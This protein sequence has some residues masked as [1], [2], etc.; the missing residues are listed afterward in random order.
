MRTRCATLSRHNCCVAT[1]GLLA[2]TTSC[3]DTVHGRDTEQKG[4]CHDREALCRNP[5]HPIPAPNLVATR[6]FC[7][8][9][10]PRVFVV[11]AFQPSAP[12]PGRAL[13]RQ[14]LSRH[15]S[16]CRNRGLKMGSSPL[17]L[18]HL[19]FSPFSFPFQHTINSM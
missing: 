3:H 17:I 7:S 9:T 2:L 5:N 19:Q 18:L 15:R 14:A 12:N 11:R 8:D 13:G 4:L 10:G 6:K 1:Q 16:P